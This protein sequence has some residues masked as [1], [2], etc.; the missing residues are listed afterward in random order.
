MSTKEVRSS[1][2]CRI[3]SDLTIVTIAIFKAREVI[4]MCFK[5]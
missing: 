4:E 2:I 3:V 1:E 5:M